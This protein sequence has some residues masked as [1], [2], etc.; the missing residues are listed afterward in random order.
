MKKCNKCFLLKNLEE[1]Y[2]GKKVCRECSRFFR[3]LKYQR[4]KKKP[5]YIQLDLNDILK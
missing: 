3:N 2:I 4:Q 1:F 5:K